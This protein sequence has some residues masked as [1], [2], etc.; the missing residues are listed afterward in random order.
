MATSTCDGTLANVSPMIVLFLYR[1]SMWKH[2]G[3]FWERINFIWQTHLDLWNLF[4]FVKMQKKR[5]FDWLY[6]HISTILALYFN[7]PPPLYSKHF[8][9]ILNIFLKCMINPKIHLLS[10]FFLIGGPSVDKWKCGTVLWGFFSQSHCCVVTIFDVAGRKRDIKINWGRLE[11]VKA[12]QS[13]LSEDFV[14]LSRSAPGCFFR[15]CFHLLFQRVSDLFSGD[16]HI[17]QSQ[18]WLLRSWKVTGGGT[19]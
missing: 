8:D 12:Q 1:L 14:A 19:C 17:S 18:L 6:P 15:R 7:F 4:S 5:T 2:F 11:E 3:H 16:T 13:P 9:F 10:F